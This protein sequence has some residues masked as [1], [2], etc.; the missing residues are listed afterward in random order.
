MQN[1]AGV[2]PMY[3][4]AI[5]PNTKWGAGVQSS[6]DDLLTQWLDP[7]PTKSITLRYWDNLLNAWTGRTAT[8]G[9]AC[10]GFSGTDFDLQP[11]EGYMLLVG[12]S[13][14]DVNTP[15]QEPYY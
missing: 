15:T 8:C 11:F 14:G 4:V 1:I 13:T 5:T 2:E 6:V 12:G 10:P 7:T 3:G 9:K